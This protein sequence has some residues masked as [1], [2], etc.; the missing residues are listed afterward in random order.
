VSHQIII[1][2]GKAYG[3]EAESPI[4]AEIIYQVPHDLSPQQ[5]GDEVA[6]IIKKLDKLYD[7]A[8]PD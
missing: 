8:V 4:S 6:K 1:R 2:G 7:L 5:V 3:H